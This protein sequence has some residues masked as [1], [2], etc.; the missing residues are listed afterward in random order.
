[1]S[2]TLQY[3]ELV[4][5]ALPASNLD[6]VLVFGWKY[7]QTSFPLLE[8]EVF[9]PLSRTGTADAVTGSLDVIECLTSACRSL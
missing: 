1:M 7:L 9:F 5:H 4:L 6:V 8:S 3:L 2:L